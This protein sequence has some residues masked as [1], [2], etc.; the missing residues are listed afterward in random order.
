MT[1]TEAEIRRRNAVEVR[2]REDGPTMVFAHGYGTSKNMW[3]RV[4]PDFEKTHRVILFDHIG[5]G[6][7]DVSLYSRAKYDSLYGYADDLNAL[8]RALGGAPVIYVGH[9]IS[10]MIGV[11]AA[12]D[13]P[14]L[15]RSLVMVAPSP[16]YINEEGYVGGFERSDVEGLLDALDA[17][18][19]AWSE[20]LAPLVMANADRPELAAELR[21][22]FVSTDTR[23][24]QHFARVT[25][26]S[27]NRSEL[28]RLTVPSLIL[29]AQ[30]DVIAP[31]EVGR[32]L[33]EHLQGSTL[34]EL[35]AAG[36]YAHL[37]APAEII[38]EVRA[39]L[40]AA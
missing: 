38:D 8:I 28:D 40:A 36:H 14:E 11:L 20:R 15:F 31:L 23:V 37:S 35:Q 26:L 19:H 39:Y 1:A 27:D 9:S 21:D 13:A 22:S 18:H 2:G 33:A 25:F 4:V 12:I 30:D 16:C 7:S 34:R 24:A 10:A 32:Y 6:Q 3:R 5:S 29:Q 17:N